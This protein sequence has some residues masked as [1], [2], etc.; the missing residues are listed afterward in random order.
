MKRFPI[1][2]ITLYQRIISPY[3]IPSC[4]FIPS[5]SVYAKGAILKYGILKG[6]LLAI[7]RV[8]RCNPLSKKIYD[9]I[10]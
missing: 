1:F 2:L 4:R 7:W 3:L 6:L 9:P 10:P 8:L 5:C